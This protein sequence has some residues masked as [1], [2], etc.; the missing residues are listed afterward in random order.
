LKEAFVHRATASFWEHYHG[1]PE[2]V[3]HIADA[4]FELLKSDPFHPSLHF[5]K[6]NGELWSARVGL[7]YRAL[8]IPEQSGFAWIWI[9]SHAAYD[10]LIS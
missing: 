1:L 4:N 3:R 6:V 2:K 10:R 5:K 7:K 8:A 9:G